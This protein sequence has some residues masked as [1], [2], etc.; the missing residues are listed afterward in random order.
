M[1]IPKRYGESR[2]DGCPFCGKQAMTKNIQTLPV[3]VEHKNSEL[4]SMKCACGSYLDIR[5]GKFGA[6]FTCINCG[7]ISM[8]KAF[9][10]NTVID[11]SAKTKSQP[12]IQDIKKTKKE[13]EI[14]SDDPNF[15]S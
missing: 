7:A 15:F 1:Y 13:I 4:G 9:E 12:K 11:V 8:S 10:I 6:F 5:N 2:K 3:C 14:R